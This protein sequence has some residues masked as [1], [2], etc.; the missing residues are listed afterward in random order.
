M[1][2][3]Y[4]NHPSEWGRR[5][6]QLGLTDD[7]LK[8]VHYRAP[9]SDEWKAKRGSLNQVA[10][11][12]REDMDTLSVDYFIVDSYTA[13][14]P[15]GDSMG[16]ATSAEEFF[17]GVRTIGRPGLVIAHVTSNSGRFPDKP[18]GQSSFTTS[19]VRHGRLRS[20]PTSP[21]RPLML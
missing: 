20:T 3:D 14:S 16:G 18:F 1:I 2:I 7:E 10:N 19:R 6:R 21:M 11:A 9:F 4:E 5:A 13:A 8:R 15:S 17:E 12:L